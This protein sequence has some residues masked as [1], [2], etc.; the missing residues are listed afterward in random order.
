MDYKK[1]ATEFLEK[2]CLDLH[3]EKEGTGKYWPDDKEKRD[4]YRWSIT[5]RSKY[6]ICSTSG[7]FG[8]SIADTGKRKPSAYDILAC[9]TKYDPETFEEFCASYGYDTDSRKA[10]ETYL[11]VQKEYE[12]LRKVLPADAWN[13]FQEIN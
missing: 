10:L 13:D 12:G 9:L 5:N 3:I 11:A 7:R 4:I 2:Y 8:Q 1:Q 6:P